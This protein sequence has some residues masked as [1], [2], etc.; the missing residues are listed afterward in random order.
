MEQSIKIGT[1]VGKNIRKARR[2]KDITQE[3][4]AARLQ[5]IGCDLAR[6][7]IGKIE[8]GARHVRADEIAAIKEILEMSYDDFFAH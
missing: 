7:T 4:L 1:R 2:A 6:S 5:V 3:Q 8:T